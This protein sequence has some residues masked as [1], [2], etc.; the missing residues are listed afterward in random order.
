M[1]QADF[2]VLEIIMGGVWCCDIGVSSEDCIKNYAKH[3]S[4]PRGQLNHSKCAAFKFVMF[5]FG[6]SRPKQEM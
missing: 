4:S 6:K 1:N 5:T 2:A 3:L